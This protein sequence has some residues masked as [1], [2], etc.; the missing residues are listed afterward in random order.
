MSKSKPSAKVPRVSRLFR[1]ILPGATLRGRLIGAV[2]AIVS[3]ALTA[4]IA[5][6]VMGDGFTAAALVAPMGAS[7]V[8]LFAVPSSPLA[9]PWP[10]IGG[11]TLSAL[12]G[13]A[14]GTLI[15]IDVVVAAVAVGGAITVMSFTRSLHPPGGAAALVA[16]FAASGP[17]GVGFDFALLPV[18]FNAC[19]LTA[20]GIVF[21]RVAGHSYP[22][23]AEAGPANRVG[24][25]DKAAVARTGFSDNDI[26]A[27]FDELG[28]ALDV[29]RDDVASFIRS[30][31]RHTL[32][33][34]YGKLLCSD[35]MARDVIRVSAGASTE[36]ARSL[37]LERGIRT[38]PVVS[39]T[40]RVVGYVGLRQ[41]TGG[42]H[43]VR[44]VMEQPVTAAASDDALTLVD[45]LTDGLHHAVIIVDDT[46]RLVGLVTQT[47]LL[48]ALAQAPPQ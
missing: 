24:T 12:V 22:L 39:E 36:E 13:V 4:L 16:A 2:G 1:P 34:T 44:E 6:L 8:L 19:L 26:D 35:I 37:I 28:H 43:L 42:G 32:A 38:L 7:A 29:S 3:I 33:R 25:T 48:A 9:Q 41:L 46:G 21:H 27:A 11:N 14:V 30:V 18:A 5:S 15:P 47:D 40:N 23:R 17:G 10:I 20:C 45:P 31:Q